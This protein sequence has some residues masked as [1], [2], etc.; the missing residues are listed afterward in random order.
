[1]LKLLV[2][3]FYTSRFRKANKHYASRET[4]G[5]RSFIE[6]DKKDPVEVLLYRPKE[7]KEAP[8][9]VQIHGGA[10]V[11]LDAVEDDEYCARLSKELG[12]FVVNVNYKRLYDKPFPYAQWECVDTVKW[13]INHAIELGI[14]K[15]RIVISGGSAGGHL[16]AGTA[17]LLARQNIKIAGQI[18]EV[19]FLDFTKTVKCELNEIQGIIE[20]MLEIYPAKRAIDDE[21]M[22]PCVA[23]DK[24]LRK[25]ANATIIVC[26][27]DPIHPQGEYYANRLK[28]V[29]NQVE[30]KMYENGYHSFGPINEEEKQ[31]QD[32]LREECFWYKVEQAKRLYI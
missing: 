17:I 1:M 3:A 12:A 8:V 6:R 23:P 19:P 22:S 25:V 26:G 4:I 15:E 20:K 11:G 29:G 28:N 2:K 24:T 18:M 27:R 30:L 21:V 16:T 14:D 9:F 32:I 7:C 13:V 31:E 5:E 10:W